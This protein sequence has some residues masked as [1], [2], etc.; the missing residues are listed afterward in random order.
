MLIYH[1]YCFSVYG[2][3]LVIIFYLEIFLLQT[4][5]PP[6]PPRP[7][8]AVFEDEEKSKVNS[9]TS[10]PHIKYMW[11]L[12]NCVSITLFF[13]EPRDLNVLK[14]LIGTWHFMLSRIN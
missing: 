13:R 8:N 12:S 1:Y 2:L 9:V 11:Y 10:V 6:P 3:L 4:M 14:M 5:I 7:Q